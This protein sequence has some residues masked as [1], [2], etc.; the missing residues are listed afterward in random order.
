MGML[1]M[2]SFEVWKLGNPFEIKSILGLKYQ[3]DSRARGRE[4][5]WSPNQGESVVI[6]C[7][8]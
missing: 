2:L 4:S 7:C 1:G 6:L 5:V 3:M 8:V